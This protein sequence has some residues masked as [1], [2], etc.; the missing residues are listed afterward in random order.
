MRTVDVN[1]D[2]VLSAA[3][4]I[5]ANQPVIMVNLLRFRDQADYGARDDVTPCTGR[6]AYYERYAPLAARLLQGEGARLV[7]LGNL[8]ASVIGPADERWDDA[9][10]VEYSSFSVLQSLLTSPAYQAI[11]FHRA[12]ALEDS[13]LIAAATA[14][15]IGGFNVLSTAA[16]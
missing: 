15:N 12:A 16:G 9:V 7:W 8:L 1:L 2:A 3:A 11:V 14:Q 6:Y 10:L 13:R 4:S 5:P